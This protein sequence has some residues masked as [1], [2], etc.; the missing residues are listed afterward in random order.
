[1]RLSMVSLLVGLIG[2]GLWA[3]TIRADNT[4]NVT[5]T[6]ASTAGTTPGKKAAA[7]GRE[8]KNR[9][10]LAAKPL[11]AK[12]RAAALKFGREHH[13]ELANLLQVLRK[14]NARHYE[15]AISELAFHSERLGRMAER[16]DE[17][18][19]ASLNLWKLE[20][21]LR[22]AVARLTM[23]GDDEIDKK[24]RPLLVERSSLRLSLLRIESKRQ[25]A[26][27]KKLEEQI[28]TLS[29]NSD[30][31]IAVEI[32]RIR[33]SIAA[34]KRRSKTNQTESTSKETV[35]KKPP[36]TPQKQPSP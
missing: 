20:S 31:R 6:N 21:R 16:S 34:G 30:E 10:G 8:K 1:M 13:P 29:S 36:R 27:L 35:R 3:D 25:T 23:A 4:S 32:E 19:S 7:A 14:A 2:L 12:A 17:R 5:V 28:A 15:T 22:L 9:A 33:K 18:Y 24:I 11:D 26:R